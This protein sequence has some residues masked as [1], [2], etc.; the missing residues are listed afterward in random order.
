MRDIR[1]QCSKYTR[2]AVMAI[3]TI[4]EAIAPRPILKPAHI[5]QISNAAV[6]SQLLMRRRR[7]EG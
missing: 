7:L 2:R 5:R 3:D 4:F 6:R 1:R